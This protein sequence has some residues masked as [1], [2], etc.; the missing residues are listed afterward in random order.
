MV[1]R[2]NAMLIEF[3]SAMHHDNFRN[4]FAPVAVVVP[5]N[6]RAK[7]YVFALQQ[8]C[9]LPP[10]NA[11]VALSIISPLGV[12]LEICLCPNQ[13]SGTQAS[14]AETGRADRPTVLAPH[15]NII[16]AKAIDIDG[17]A[18][19]LSAAGP[20]LPPVVPAFASE[21]PPAAMTCRVRP[22]TRVRVL[23]PCGA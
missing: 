8:S 18:L 1:Q 21:A 3:I 19:R 7:A 13:N 6:V 11:L 14:L 23:I 22:P 2:L 20:N 5:Q 9:A 17:F 4:E 16:N 15:K 10:T 12:A